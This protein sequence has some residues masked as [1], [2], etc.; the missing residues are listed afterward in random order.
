MPV[1]LFQHNVEAM[2][3]QRHAQVAAMLQ[4]ADDAP[5]HQ[6]R[7]ETTADGLDLGKLRH[8]SLTVGFPALSSPALRRS[9][10]VAA[11]AVEGDFAIS[12]A[13]T[14]GA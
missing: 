8:G 11:I 14:V 12:C 1:V 3:W 4:Q 6:P 2:I 7:D 5:A 10:L 9:F 13:H